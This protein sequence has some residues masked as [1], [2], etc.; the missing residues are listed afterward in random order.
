MLESR[1]GLLDPALGQEDEIEE[2][3]DL[4]RS[5]LA[6]P[7]T[8]QWKRSGKAA[9]QEPLRETPLVCV[10]LWKQKKP[11]EAWKVYI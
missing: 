10:Q 2:L 7:G 6:F 1:L 3:C 9:N 4:A 5:L 8:I 11:K